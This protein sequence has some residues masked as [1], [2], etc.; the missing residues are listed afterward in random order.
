MHIS[1]IRFMEHLA[2][3]TPISLEEFC[4]LMRRELALPE[5]KFDSEDETEWCCVEH[6]GIEFNISRPYSP[7]TLQDWDDSVPPN[8]NFGVSLMVSTDCP[9]SQDLTW[10]SAELVP[11]VAR[12]LAQSLGR[13]VHH[14]RTWLGVGENLY[15]SQTFLPQ[16]NDA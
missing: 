14:H 7:G 13:T 9:R 12:R 2:V 11:E 1:R 10:A 15:P 16:P 4:N 3:E 6:R 8:A 5:F